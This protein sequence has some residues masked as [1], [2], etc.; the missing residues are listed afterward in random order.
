MAA[1]LF[2]CLCC[3]EILLIPPRV[4]SAGV[5]SGR[6]AELSRVRHL[7]ASSFCP[8]VKQREIRDIRVLYPQ[9]IVEI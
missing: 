3:G 5:I 7:G 8:G 9:P 4:A 1:P 6:V 2:Q